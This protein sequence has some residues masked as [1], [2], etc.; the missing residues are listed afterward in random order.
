MAEHG[1]GG[2]GQDRVVVAAADLVALC[3]DYG[4][5]GAGLLV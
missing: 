3:V 4:D 5:F 2:C 1:T